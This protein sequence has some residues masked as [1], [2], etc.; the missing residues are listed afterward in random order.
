MLAAYG[1]RECRVNLGEISVYR[2]WGVAKEEGQSKPTKFQEIRAERATC[3]RLSFFLVSFPSSDGKRETDGWVY[4]SWRVHAA[5]VFRRGISISQ[6]QPDSA[7]RRGCGEG[8]LL[9]LRRASIGH[10]GRKN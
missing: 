7:R 1:D 4:S 9:H 3:F 10:G 8:G 2:T 6:P 5:R